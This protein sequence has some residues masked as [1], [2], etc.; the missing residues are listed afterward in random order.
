MVGHSASML[1]DGKVLVCGGQ[2]ASIYLSSCEVYDP[3]TGIW[4]ITNSMNDR[5][6]FHTASVLL[7]GKVLVTGGQFSTWYLKSAELYSY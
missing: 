7:D 5:R 1:L 3:S 2:D 4:I 6:I